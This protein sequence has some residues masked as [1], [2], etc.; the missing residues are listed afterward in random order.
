M[1]SGDITIFLKVS[2]INELRITGF[3][4]GSIAYQEIADWGRVLAVL[5]SLLPKTTTAD[6]II[7]APKIF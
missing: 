7:Q 4:A 2:V 1:N 5:Y 6:I 3:T